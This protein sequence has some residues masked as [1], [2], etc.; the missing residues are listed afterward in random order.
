MIVFDGSGSMAEIGYNLIEEPRIFEAREAIATV[1]PPVAERRRL[2]LL[3]YGPGGADACSGVD[4]RFAPREEAAGP[5]IDAVNALEPAGETPLTEAVREAAETLLTTGG[6]GDV[7][8]VTDGKE[9]C[10]GAPCQLATELSDTGVTVHVI[11]FKVR[12]P[13]FAWK[14]GVS[15]SYNQ[16]ETVARCLADATEGLYVGAE[17][18]EELIDALR[19]TLGC[20]IMM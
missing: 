14:E 16:S 3:L 8:L 12:G 5:I 2:G 15:D 10:A 18:L 7:V 4:L 20:R 6:P 11:G 1:V 9:T 17:T 19:T 13:H